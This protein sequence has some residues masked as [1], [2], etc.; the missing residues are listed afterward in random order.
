MESIISGDAHPALHSSTCSLRLIL[1]RSAIHR[2]AERLS[3][4]KRFSVF[5]KKL[6]NGKA[7]SLTLTEEPV[8]NGQLVGSSCS[9]ANNSFQIKALQ[10]SHQVKFALDVVADG[11]SSWKKWTTT[12]TTSHLHT[13]SCWPQTLR[14]VHCWTSSSSIKLQHNRSLRLNYVITPL[15]FI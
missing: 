9:P 5:A 14:S 13:P 15:H 1:G 10:P 11:T 6:V 2:R 12:T 4:E 3:D 8:N 7:K